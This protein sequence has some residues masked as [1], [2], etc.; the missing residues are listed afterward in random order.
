VFGL[1]WSWERDYPILEQTSVAAGQPVEPPDAAALAHVALVDA[2]VDP[3]RPLAG[4]EDRAPTGAG[5]PLPAADVDSPGDTAAARAGG[6]GAGPESVSDQHYL[7][8]TTEQPWSDP[9]ITQQQRLRNATRARSEE[10]ILRAPERG[11][12]QRTA[13]ARPRADDG[14]ERGRPG[15]DRG[16][17][18]AI[19]GAPGVDWSRMDP[20][21]QQGAGERV[22]QRS[23]GAVQPEPAQGFVIERGATSADALRD[24]RAGDTRTVAGASAERDPLPADLITPRSGGDSG[25]GFRGRERVGH[26]AQGHGRGSAATSAEIATGAGTAMWARRDDPYFR[27]FHDRLDREVRFPRQL[28]IRLEQGQ[29]VARFVLRADGS[30]ADIEVTKPSGFAEFDRELVRALRALSPLGP[31]PRSFLGRRD[32]VAVLLDYEFK[33]PV[34]R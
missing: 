11:I 34:I 20:R 7:R 29:L 33:N 28:A 2:P 16:T 24:G 8:A 12:A 14:A 9:T 15:Q 22:P 6:A 25:D 31:V 19:E 32:R 13:P 10:A 27:R 18:Q 21:Y 4:A 26:S 30:L 23:P 1:F 5:H 3:L 17:A